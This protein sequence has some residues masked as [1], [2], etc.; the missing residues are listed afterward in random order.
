MVR[1]AISSYIETNGT[2]EA[3]YEVDLVARI[4]GPVVE[5]LAEEGDVV[6]KDALLA[7]LDDNELRS[8]L[9]IARVNLNETRLAH[10]RAKSLQKD[11]LISP[12]S[13]DQVASAYETAQAQYDGNLIQLGYVEIRAPFDGWIV[14]RYVDLAE[15][16]ATGQGLFRIS[17]FTPLLCPIQVPERELRRLRKDQNA[18]VT[19]EAFPGERFEASVLRISPVVDA[20]T[21]T[22][23]VTLEVAARDLLRPGMFARVFLETDRRE[24]AL[25]IPKM[26]LSLESIGDTIYVARDGTASRREVELGYAEGD[27]IEVLSGVVEN[28]PVVVV[29]QDGLSDGTPI[30]VLGPAGDDK[31]PPASSPALAASDPRGGG[32]LDITKATPEQIER[33]KQ[34]MRARGLT[35]EQIEDRLRQ[36][37]QRAGASSR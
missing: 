24:G 17:D 36:A 5:L 16:V 4:T 7:R 22:I 37:R 10:E 6:K 28:E 27:F 35:E 14:R 12:E 8:Q 13:F 23:K 26:A 21:G 33:I 11:S 31:G 9:E 2:L 32:R 29:G 19:V 18:H 3:E 1:R 20:T 34:F 15:H 25:V 30:R